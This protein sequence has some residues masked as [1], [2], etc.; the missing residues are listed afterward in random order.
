MLELTARHADQWNVWFSPI[1][2]SVA[3]LKTLL[4]DV[5]AAC[6]V[7]G[8]EPETLERTAAVKVEVGPHS[9]SQMSVAPLTGS[10]DA[11]AEQLRAYAAIGVTQV[12]VWPEPNS[13]EGIEKFA[14]VLEALDRG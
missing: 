5:D 13:L 2:N 14:R 4:E 3:K 9:P 12:Q 1:D 8:R 10:P 7:I 11:L 6:A